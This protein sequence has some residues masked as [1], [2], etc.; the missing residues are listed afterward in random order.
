MTERVRLLG[1][2]CLLQSE[3]YVGTRI[4]VRL[5]IPLAADET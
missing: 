5:P 1:G 4:S 2:E 3:Q